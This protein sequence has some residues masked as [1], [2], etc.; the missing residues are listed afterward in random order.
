MSRV[1]QLWTALAGTLVAVLLLSGCGTQSTD[2]GGT[3]GGTQAQAPLAKVHLEPGGGSDVNPAAPVKVSVEGG[4]LDDVALT[5]GDGKEVEGDLADDGLS[6]TAG[7]QLGYGKTYTWSGEATG[8]DGKSVP[9]QGSFT[10]ISP[11][12]QVRATVNPTDHSEVGV[13]MPISVK[14][15]DPVTDKAAAE[16][17]LKVRTSVPVEGAWAWLSDTQVDWRPK[18]YWPAGT[19]VE[20]DAD[21]YG[22]HYGEGEYGR[23]DLTTEF[24]IGRSQVVKADASTHQMV[25]ERDGKQV[26]SYAASYGKDHDPELNTPNGT[27][28]VMQKNPVEI[29]D[30]PRYG[31]TDVE[32]KW[33]VRMSNHGEFIHENEENRANLGKV[34]T[35]HGCIN[36]SEADAKSYFDTALVG[37]PI[38]VTGA[39]ASMEPR[40]DVFDWM[41]DWDQ[42]TQKSA[43]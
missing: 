32:K 4:K 40:Y 23:S 19:E 11:A 17:A 39:V 36:L 28:I 34:N 31:Y 20:V 26:A 24:T 37:D 12:K 22:V 15:D 16:R 13:A 25:V 35:S 3:G 30:N 33:A 2:G 14:F 42:W 27:Y 9:V 18:E 21:L 29:M 38:E 8:T 5:N 7:E 43:L 41:L 10:T 6:W 1:R